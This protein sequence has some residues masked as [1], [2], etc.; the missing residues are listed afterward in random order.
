[1]AYADGVYAHVPSVAASGASEAEKGVCEFELSKEIEDER[2][3]YKIMAR[4]FLGDFY[5]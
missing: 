1:M 2:E 5:P 3:L 4:G